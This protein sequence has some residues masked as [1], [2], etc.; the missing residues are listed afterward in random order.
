MR[1]CQKHQLHSISFTAVRSASSQHCWILQNGII[2]RDIKLENI[3]LDSEGHIV[4]T[5]FGL[6]REFRA[7]E[8]DRR[9]YSFCGT[10]E[11]MAPE[12]VRGGNHGHDIVSWRPAC[13]AA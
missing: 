10:I 12:V 13:W 7:D 8:S 9:A 5:D 2:Y 4:L 11:Y 6:S 3:L 1:L